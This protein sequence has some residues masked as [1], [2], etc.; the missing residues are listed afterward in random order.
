MKK[1]RKNSKYI[2]NTLNGRKEKI[3]KREN[4]EKKKRM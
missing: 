4:N 1:K 3:E 2:K